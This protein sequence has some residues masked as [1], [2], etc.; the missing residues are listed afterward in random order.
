M[1][2][3]PAQQN[4]HCQWRRWLPSSFLLALTLITL[5]LPASAQYQ[6]FYDFHSEW[7]F[8]PVHDRCAPPLPT[9]AICSYPSPEENRFRGYIKTIVY[10]WMAERKLAPADL[11]G[12]IYKYGRKDLISDIQAYVA[13][14]LLLSLEKPAASRTADEQFVVSYF[15]REFATREWNLYNYAVQVGES[16]QKD[17]C[18]WKPDPELAAAYGLEYDST[19]YCRTNQSVFISASTFQIPG[20]KSEYLY[21]AGYKEIYGGSATSAMMLDRV[22]VHLGGAASAVT[23]GGVAGGIIG[24]NI[25]KITPYARAVH[26]LKYASDV[27]KLRY[28]RYTR[29]LS[30]GA[31]TIV[32]MMIEIGVEGIIA[33]AEGVKFQQDLDNFRATRDR[34]AGGQDTVTAVTSGEGLAKSMIIM[35]RYGSMSAMDRFLKYSKEEPLP[36]HRPGIDRV[37][38]VREGGTTRPAEF[39]DVKDHAD[40][41]WRVYMWQNWFVKRTTLDGQNVESITTD[42]DVTDH[43]GIKWTLTRVGADRFRMTQVD[44]R[45]DA[46]VCPSV[47][48]ISS[49]TDGTCSVYFSD[50]VN[51]Q[52]A[53]G[54]KVNLHVGI[55]P[56]IESTSFFFPAGTETSHPVQ[57]NGI[58]LPAVQV[59]TRP[60]WLRMSNGTLIGNPGTAAGKSVV[61]VEVKTVSGT[62]RKDI[63][64][65]YGQPVQ[66]MSPA[67]VAVMAAE[68]VAFTINTAGT[69]RPKITMT[70]WLPSF[71]S[72]TDNGNG[73]ATLRGVW[74][75]GIAPFCVP[76]L[77][78]AGKLS[79]CGTTIIAEN[80]A[81]R[82][83]QKLTF[84]FISQPIAVF[85]G[86]TDL[87]FVAGVESRYL[88]TTTGARTPVEWQTLYGQRL[89]DDLLRTL[90]WLRLDE[91]PDE[92]TALVYGIPPL[93][94]QSSSTAFTACP[95]ARGSQ[96]AN[97]G[98]I[99]NLKVTVDAATRFMS[100]PVGSITVGRGG[101]IQVFVNRLTG[102]FGSSPHHSLSG[103]LPKGLRIEPAA[104][105]RNGMVT[106]RILG[107]PEPGQGG[108]YEFTLNWTDQ[109]NSVD[110]LFRLDVLEPASIT[111]PATFTF[112]E[113]TNAAGQVTTQ[114][115][116]V[117]S[118]GVDCGLG[119]DC[120]DMSIALVWVRRVEGLT[121]KDRS[122]QGVPTGVGRFEGAIPSGSSGIYEAIVRASNG[123]MRPPFEQRVRLVVLPKADLNGDGQVDCSDLT[124]IKNAIGTLQPGAG[125]GFDLTGDMLV[126]NTDIDAMVR[127]VP[128]LCTCQI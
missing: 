11:E 78:S 88:L 12:V 93:N 45:E 40:L 126:D 54:A 91:R 59:G 9:S 110:S 115:Y 23:G 35:A 97:C 10:R 86:P 4:V 106:A 43:N 94:G 65:Y 118:A 121:L 114:G 49:R 13:A 127:A 16:W 74:N 128:D 96:Y 55:A 112:F 79:D 76:S 98:V 122:D 47:N 31:F 66:F 5:A 119:K 38:L 83:E 75:G 58:P 14:D 2:K 36:E 103:R 63:T 107:S 29:L 21:A 95:F 109:L 87:K 24:K 48:G 32:T 7:L 84:S 33:F 25:S 71:L 70:G 26:D 28:L 85:Q 111:S 81:Q 27:A 56:T 99:G 18:S 77:D 57:V 41:S 124:A 50:N 123:T 80:D 19:P 37:F 105:Q 72:M 62:S 20:P 82:V 15:E 102:N 108:R 116:P 39:L 22:A 61:P 113:G 69:P 90:P 73:T 92:G 125:R 46:T 1:L 51:I 104:P 101:D 42:L 8:P 44:A 100:D 68:S 3:N 64:V 52:L 89:R 17:P 6:T 60:A 120:G 53:N 67:T 30:G 34:L 117:N